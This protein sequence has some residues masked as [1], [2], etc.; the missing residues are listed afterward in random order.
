MVLF[1]QGGDCMAKVISECPSCGGALKIAVLRC[2]D[3]GMELHNDFQR[4]PFDSLTADQT[5]FLISFLR[6]RGKM[7]SLQEELGISYPT[8]KKKLDDLL[9]VLKLVDNIAQVEKE[10]ELVDMSDWFIPKDSNKASDIIKKMLMEN[11]GRAIVHTAQGLPREI[12]VAPDAISF[13][14]DELAIKPPYQYEVFD[15]IVDL[16]ISQGGRARKGNGRNFKLGEPDCDETTVVGAI[17]YNYAHK[18]TGTSVFD[19]VFALAAILE[20]AGIASNERGE[21]VLTTN[22]QEKLRAATEGR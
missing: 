9:T 22:Y 3:C 5:E 17:G 6:Q 19:P 14:C 20:W 15:K 4:G 21:L 7:S 2:S 10:E 8:A 11:G 13:L 12:R 1:S 18:E 16:L